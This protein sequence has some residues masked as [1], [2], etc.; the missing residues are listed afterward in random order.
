MIYFYP[1]KRSRQLSPQRWVSHVIKKPCNTQCLLAE[2]CYWEGGLR[3]P[4]SEKVSSVW[5]ERKVA[6]Y[7]ESSM[8]RQLITWIMF[9][10]AGFLCSANKEQVLIAVAQR[11]LFGRAGWISVNQKLWPQGWISVTQLVVYLASTTQHW[12]KLE[13]TKPCE[14]ESTIPE[15]GQD[16]IPVVVVYS[17]ILCG[18]LL[19]L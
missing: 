3:A 12:G 5:L 11:D 17:F 2:C 13:K 18:T 1:H 19:S 15:E 10:R 7:R 9:I 6:W 8:L 4:C 16:D 14:K